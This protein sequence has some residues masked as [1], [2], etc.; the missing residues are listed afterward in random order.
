MAVV[1]AKFECGDVYLAKRAPWLADFE[2][3]LFAFPGARH[4]GQCDSVPT[5]R[6]RFRRPP[7]I[8]DWS[9]GAALIVTLL[10]EAI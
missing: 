4:D 3:E 2:R 9:A 1:S 6:R 10:S 7:A 8:P 5:A